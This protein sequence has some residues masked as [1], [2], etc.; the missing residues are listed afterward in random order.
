VSLERLLRVLTETLNS[1]G[2]PSM[3]T[4]SVAAAFRGASRA[5]LEWA[6]LG[7]SARQLDDVR[8]LLRIAG[9]DVDRSYLDR[10]I[11]ALG[12]REQWEAA[13]RE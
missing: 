5:T 6:K 1:T 8:M 10:W 13:R 11:A 2:I 9:D 12:L 7:A 4:G 3:L